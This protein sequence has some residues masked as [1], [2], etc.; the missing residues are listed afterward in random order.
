[1]A[2][3]PCACVPVLAHRLS[4]GTGQGT[5]G[6]MGQGTEQ[7]TEAG[8]VPGPE[9][10]PEDDGLA[11]DAAPAGEWVSVAEAARRLQVTPKAIRNRLRRGTLPARVRGN[12]GREVW[13]PRFRDRPEPLS[14][15]RQGTGPGTG[16]GTGPEQVTLLVENARLTA[17][18]EGER[19]LNAELRRQMA[20]L[21][22]EL[23]ELRTPWWARVLAAL[24]R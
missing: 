1:M 12:L 19:R 22:A 7:G 15:G 23:T 3:L 20:R 6:G 10:E 18:V 5:A 9:T 24:R 4:P 21:E 13:L 16:T 8:Q 11:A 17:E 14:G 2:A